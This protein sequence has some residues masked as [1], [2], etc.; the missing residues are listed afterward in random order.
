MPLGCHLY[1]L[2]PVVTTS[3][4]ACRVVSVSVCVHLYSTGGVKLGQCS[5]V[6]V[7]NKKCCV[8]MPTGEL[9]TQHSTQ[10]AHGHDAAWQSQCLPCV[11]LL[12]C[13]LC[14]SNAYLAAHFTC[15]HL[16][17]PVDIQLHTQQHQYCSDAA[18]VAES[19][20]MSTGV[21]CDNSVDTYTASHLEA[22]ETRSLP[23]GLLLLRHAELWHGHG[24][25]AL[26]PPVVCLS[27][28]LMCHFWTG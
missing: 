15:C 17:Q 16:R 14:A 24:S 4:Y 28:H 23:F 9:S 10:S 25:V 3:F 12:T 18:A 1:T 21:L 26:Y 13:M 20:A 6:F 22:Y 5:C 7:G 19:L 27:A 8:S 2:L 11:V